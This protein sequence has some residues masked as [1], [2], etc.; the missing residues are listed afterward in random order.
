MTKLLVLAVLVGSV[1]AADGQMINHA[2]VESCRTDPARFSTCKTE[3]VWPGEP[4]L[5]PDSSY[6]VACSIAHSAKVHISGKP[7]VLNIEK[8]W[9]LVTVTIANF[10]NEPASG[11]LDCIA[12]KGIKRDE[13]Q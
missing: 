4:G 7:M 6:T 11:E 8:H 5:F 13:A 12:V 10:G 9:N 3:V 2:R 1:I